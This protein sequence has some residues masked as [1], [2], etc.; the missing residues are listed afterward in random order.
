[1]F[2]GAILYAVSSKVRRAHRV[3]PAPSTG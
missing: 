3:R 2:L 1:V